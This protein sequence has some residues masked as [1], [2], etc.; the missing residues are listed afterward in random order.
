MATWRLFK[1]GLEYV[2]RVDVD[3]EAAETGVT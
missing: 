1:G 3:L 2:E